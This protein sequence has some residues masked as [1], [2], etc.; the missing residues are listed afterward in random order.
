MR[1]DDLLAQALERR[2]RGGGD[3]PLVPLL[4]GAE[5]AL[6]VLRERSGSER[7]IPVKSGRLPACRRISTSA[8]FETPTNGD[9]STVDERLVVVAVVE[10]PQV[11]E[12]VDDLLLAEVPA[13][14]R[15]IGR[16]PVGARSA[17][18]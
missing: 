2:P 15:A 10:Q 5:Q 7:S 1:R 12:Q 14:G 8:S 6:V 4:E 18:S 13:A 11:R 3:E 9:A 17:A 16:Q